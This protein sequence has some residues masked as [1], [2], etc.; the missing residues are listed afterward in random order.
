MVARI[1]WRLVD[2]ING[3][4][5]Q[6]S[7][8]FG[9]NGKSYIIDLTDGNAAEFRDTMSKWIECARET[10]KT[11]SKRSGKMKP[12][13]KSAK[14]DA[15]VLRKD[16]RGWAKDNNLDISNKGPISREIHEAYAARNMSRIA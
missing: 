7:I 15:A 13:S 9:F 4:E 10:P 14:K 5:A 16:I 3:E 8:E 11:G 1:E 12:S 6:Q 2:D